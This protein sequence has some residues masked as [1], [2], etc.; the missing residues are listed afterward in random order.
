MTT[1]GDIDVQQRP[2]VYDLLQNRGVRQLTQ[3]HVMSVD[4]ASACAHEGI[5]L[6]GTDVGANNPSLAAAA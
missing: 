5:V 6:F 3:V 1:R 2:T 4:E